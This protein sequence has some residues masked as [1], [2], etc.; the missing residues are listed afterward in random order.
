MSIST[1]E[2]NQ[3]AL[4]DILVLY[5]QAE[6]KMI[7]RV[8]K[9]VAKGAKDTGWNE[10]KLN[11]VINLKNEVESILSGTGSKVKSKVGKGILKAYKEGVNSAERDAGEPQTAMADLGIPLSVQNLILTINGLV[12]DGNSKILR[13]VDDAYKE[14]MASSAAGILSGVET[15]MSASQEMM[16]RLAAKG[17]SSFTDKAGRNWDM[18]SYTE[19]AMRSASNH[20]ALLGHIQTQESLGND[21]MCSNTIGTTCPICA[22]WQGVVL[23]ISGKTPGY[24][25][26]DEAKAA[27]FFHPNCRHNLFMWDPYIDGE[28]KK[29]LNSDSYVK[30]KTER[31]ALTQK[32]R[33]NERSIR[34]WKRMK[35]AALTPK[36]VAKCKQKLFDVLNKQ[37]VFCKEN[38][39]RRLPYREGVR[40]PKKIDVSD[41]NFG[42]NLKKFTIKSV[43]SNNPYTKEELWDI[44]MDYDGAKENIS[45]IYSEVTGKAPLDSKAKMIDEVYS[46]QKGSTKPPKKAKET[47]FDDVQPKPAI[48]IYTEDELWEAE[49]SE[50]MELYKK[51][52]GKTVF[53]GT[54]SEVISDVLK[55][56]KKQNEPAKSPTN[57]KVS[58]HVYTA[59]ELDDMIWAGSGSLSEGAEKV[60]EI[61]KKIIGKDPPT[62]WSDMVKEIVAAQNN[63]HFTPAPV[64]PANR[65]TYDPS[66]VDDVMKEINSQMMSRST[67]EGREFVRKLGAKTNK[68]LDDTVGY[69]FDMDS[70]GG[71]HGEIAGWETEKGN[72]KGLYALYDYTESSGKFNRPARGEDRGKDAESYSNNLG[73]L[74]ESEYYY[75]MHSSLDKL[76]NDV[77]GLDE[78][79]VLKRRSDVTSLM[80]MIDKDYAKR[81]Y[82]EKQ[83]VFDENI[84]K[85][86]SQ[87]GKHV[88]QDKGY[89]SLG[90]VKEAQ[91]SGEVVYMIK[92]KKGTK[93]IYSEPLSHYSGGSEIET[94]AK[95][96]QKFKVIKVLDDH[97]DKAFKDGFNA[98][99]YNGN[100][101]DVQYVVY[102]ESIPD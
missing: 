77:E 55:G 45:K 21:L 20:A 92:A 40:S 28:G 49:N 43:D 39:L 35:A 70:N 82:D 93:V 41:G 53:P 87:P 34:Y 74:T 99:G 27:G 14:T 30:E 42:K 75:K 26:V 85:I 88:A 83:K 84:K 6:E 31:Y 10:D 90:T 17:I 96:G 81:S 52:T 24:R 25:T 63:P 12:D 97:S 62:L 48:K 67:K 80:G 57:A 71:R 102:L 58:T 4:Q 3:A 8:A 65:N 79:I 94:I 9:R 76:F 101:Y 50:L 46:T 23:S 13:K 22:S 54:Y 73:R 36:E 16:S 37:E 47:F 68:L 61:Y 89:L 51:Y 98:S 100:V 7:K 66:L 5:T 18:G 95:R 32:Q 19:M 91:W 69:H 56:Q 78:D 86:N 29:E 11:E 33:S 60:G 15:R 38:N 72:K 44:A 59:K 64:S 2:I 1:E